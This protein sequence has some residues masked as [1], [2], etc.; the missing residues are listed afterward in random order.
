MMSLSRLMLRASAPILGIALAGAAV[1][2]SGPQIL[3]DH[4]LFFVGS[5]DVDAFL[6]EARSK[7]LGR[8]LKEQEV[9]DFLEKPMAML[10]V[11][12]QGALLEARQHEAAQSQARQRW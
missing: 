10:H 12:I 2:Q 1:A 3:P 4:T 7:P 5:D 8:I 9:Q 11:A 6:R